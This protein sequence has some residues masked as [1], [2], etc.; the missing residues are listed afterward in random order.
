M[1]E[2]ERR[3]H[4]PYDVS[5]IFFVVQKVEPSVIVTGIRSFSAPALAENKLIIKFCLF[6]LKALRVNEYSFMYVFTSSKCNQISLADV[7][8]FHYVESAVRS[9]YY[10]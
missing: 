7:A 4:D 1:I 6:V 8:V 2:S 3:A 10:A 5:L 9:E